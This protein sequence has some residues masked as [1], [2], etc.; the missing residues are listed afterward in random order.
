MTPDGRGGLA[1]GIDENGLLKDKAYFMNGESINRLENGTEFKGLQIPSF[2][3]I[4]S[5]VEKVH[6]RMPFFMFIGFDIA[7]NAEGE[8]IV[9]EYNVKGPGNFLY[10]YTNGP[11][12][13]VHTDNVIKW[14]K[15]KNI[16]R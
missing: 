11:T 7:I 12:F 5:I 15:S 1:I 14:L 3:E 2:N 13:G 16:I 9:M 4:K 6:S 10:Q 8:P